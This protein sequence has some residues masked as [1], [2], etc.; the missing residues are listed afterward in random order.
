M[1]LISPAHVRRGLRRLDDERA[2]AFVAALW[3]ARGAETS[4]DPDRRVVDVRRE[5]RTERLVVVTG[6]TVSAA[7]LAAGDRLVLLRPVE[8][9]RD[10]PTDRVIDADDIRELLLYGLPRAEAARLCRKFFDRP[11]VTDADSSPA[12][13]DSVRI[14]L[15]EQS[16]AVVVGL[17]GLVLVV[18]SVGG[19]LFFGGAGL[20]TD[21]GVLFSSAGAGEG[22]FGASESTASNTTDDWD[23]PTAVY[24]D[25]TSIR[26]DAL[27]PGISAKGDIDEDVLANAHARAVTGQSYRWT[28]THREFVDGKATAY[29]RETVYVAAP[30]RYRTELTGAGQLRNSPLAISSVEAYADGSSRFENRVT[31]DGFDRPQPDVQSVRGIRNGE[32]RYADRAE[33]YIEWY[34][35]VSESSIVDVFERD[36]TRYVWLSLGADPYPGV[37][38]STGSAL[39]DENG[40]VHEVRRQY[41]V[42][43]SGGVTAVVSFRYTDFGTTTVSPPSWH[44]RGET[45][46]TTANETTANATV[47]ESRTATGT[48]SPNTPRP[49]NESADRER[50]PATGRPSTE[51]AG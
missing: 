19:P 45:N 30:N 50:V 36:G 47:T 15:S 49:T 46:A 23:H 13:A 6:R 18:A 35:S 26:A 39:V 7:D 38:N 2:L 32:G 12:P 17:V 24:P 4:V 44:D 41:T 40:I 21:A 14:R 51:V 27:P 34:L 48:P 43:R 37:E 22:Q 25:K 42:P 3:E 8:R 20:G 33:T 28:L 16:A 10:A 11:L 1:G 29:R 5:G 31:D 9:V